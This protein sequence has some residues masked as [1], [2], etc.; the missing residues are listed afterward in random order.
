VYFL[1][2]LLYYGVLCLL[3][4]HIFAG[5]HAELTVYDFQFS[6]ARRNAHSSYESYV[7]FKSCR[8][9]PE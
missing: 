7:E 6:S 1:Q 4:Y 9:H 8:A 5:D 2:T 3:S